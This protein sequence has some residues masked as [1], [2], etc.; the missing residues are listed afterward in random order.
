MIVQAALALI[1]ADGLDGLTMRKVADRLEASAGALYGH[2]ANKQQLLE[3]LLDRVFQGIEIPEANAE[4]WP[5]QIK[6][7]CREIRD[8]LRSHRDLARVM[9]G[10]IP[11]GPSFARLLE[12]QL[13]FWDDAGIPAPLAA[14]MGDLLGLYIAAF[15]FEESLWAEHDAAPQTE[16]DRITAYLAAL[17]ID[18]FPNIAAVRD[19]MMGIGHD[20]RFELGLEIILQGV[21]RLKS[22]G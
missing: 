6:Q 1:D 9:L 12:Q 15:T 13:A 2:V 10:R 11:V 16:I 21:A 3:L 19:L 17:P 14:Y 18:R 8:R 4:E 22:P 5:E 20:E 7:T